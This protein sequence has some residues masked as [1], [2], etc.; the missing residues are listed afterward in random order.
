MVK[1][2]TVSEVLGI[3]TIVNGELITADDAETIV[4]AIEDE[5]KQKSC[6]LT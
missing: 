4:K 3:F 5:I 6:L 2:Y 1:E